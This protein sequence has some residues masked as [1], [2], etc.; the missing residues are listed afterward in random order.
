MFWNV[1][2]IKGAFLD[3]DKSFEILNG[4]KTLPQRM[5]QKCINTATFCKILNKNK[6][7]NINCNTIKEHKNHE[8]KERMLN[9]RL[10]APLFTMDFEGL[11]IDNTV[12]KKFFDSLSPAF[13]LQISLGQTNTTISCPALT[14]HSEMDVNA[15]KKTGLY[16]TTMRVSIGNE[17][18]KDLISHFMVCAKRT[19]GK[20]Y[21][22]FLDSFPSESEINKIVESE[23]LKYHKNYI[24]SL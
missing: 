22:D 20:V 8:I 4:I 12:F 10:P 14:T 16:Y 2:Y 19:I 9:Y 23:Y 6:Y 24:S 15:L 17:N 7:I 1:Y 13:N 5:L 3:S 18:P 21:P 11:N